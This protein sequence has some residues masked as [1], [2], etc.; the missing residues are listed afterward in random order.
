[1]RGLFL[2][3]KSSTRND[4]PMLCQPWAISSDDKNLSQP[5]INV[6]VFLSI[7]LQPLGHARFN[8][9]AI[10]YSLPQRLDYF[11]EIR[12]TDPPELQPSPI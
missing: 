4:P 1:M 3:S 2:L 11:A 5:M 10:L 12:I 7:A 9:S 6:S 8:A